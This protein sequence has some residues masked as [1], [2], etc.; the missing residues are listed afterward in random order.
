MSE[1][2]HHWGIFCK[3]RMRVEACLE[4]G[5]LH[6]PSNTEGQCSNVE[7]S[8]SQIVKAG[9]QHL[10]DAEKQTSELEFDESIES[11]A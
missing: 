1:S 7:L 10:D 3:G 9:Y 8:E 11:A 4:C 6:L 5:D 2:N